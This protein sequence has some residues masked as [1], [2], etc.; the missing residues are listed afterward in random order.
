MEPGAFYSKH[1]CAVEPDNV[2]KGGRDVSIQPTAAGAAVA[3]RPGFG[4]VL[5]FWQFYSFRRRGAM[6]M[7]GQSRRIGATAPPCHLSSLD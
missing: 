1:T 3:V 4:F 2:R 7:A 6:W 5:G